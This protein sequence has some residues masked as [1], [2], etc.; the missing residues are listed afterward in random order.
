MGWTSGRRDREDMLPGVS[1][2]TRISG[3]A[4]FPSAVVRSSV[5]SLCDC[6]Q[7]V[8]KMVA[9]EVAPTVQPILEGE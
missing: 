7:S 2:M 8:I 5:S 9:K 4:D 6:D 1:A 3:M